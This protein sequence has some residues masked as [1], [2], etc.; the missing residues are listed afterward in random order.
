[1]SAPLYYPHPTSLNVLYGNLEG[2]AKAGAPVF[3]GTAGT[4]VIRTNKQGYEFYAH[5]YYDGDG[6][7]RE[8]YVS[9]PVGDAQAD[10]K[11]EELKTRIE[12]AKAL[13][14]DLRLL[15]REGYQLADSKTYATLA[16]LHLHG[17][18]KAGALL[19]GSHAFG[20][21]LNQMGVK[22]A[23][24]ATE[25]IDIARREALA[26]P[27]ALD[28][29]FLDILRES[30]IPFVEVPKLDPR[31]PSTTVKQRGMSR[32]HVDLLVPSAD[33]SFPTVSVPELQA[34]A[35]GLPYLA[36]LLG[37]SQEAALL[38]REGCCLVRVPLPERFALHKLLV[39]QLRTSRD[40]K[41]EKDIFQAAVMLAV[42]GERFPG[43]IEEAALKLPDSARR[44]V[45]SAMELV[46]PRLEE[47]YP[48]SW[49]ELE[50]ALA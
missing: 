23:A 49:A 13:T 10:N 27:T 6:K 5:R 21:L 22:S 43:A 28:K 45:R 50:E 47:N 20:I 35:T 44:Y 2:H 41:T 7:Q 32:F 16:S 25:D 3:A 11:A 14:P 9:G 37:E 31:E 12:E 4:V 1:M 40:S 39:S 48:R 26:F 8:S 17:L 15:G 18:F 46:R 30:G 42:L 38:S 33:D 36:Y 19:I 29:S 24:Y 34:H